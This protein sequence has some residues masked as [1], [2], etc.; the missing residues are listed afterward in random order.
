MA[1]FLLQWW[2]WPART[3]IL[4]IPHAVDIERFAFRPPL[5]SSTGTPWPPGGRPLRLVAIGH[6]ARHKEQHVLVAMVAALRERGVEAHLSLTVDPDDDPAY[7]AELQSAVT[8]RGLTAHVE[9]TGR[10]DDPATLLA[11]ADIAL[12]ASRSESFGFPLIEAMAAGVPVV[13][14]D[15]PASREVAGRFGWF[16]PTGDA[17]AAADAVQAV[18]ATPVDVL[19]ARLEAAHAAVVER[20]GWSRN[21]EAVAAAVEDAVRR[22]GTSPGAGRRGAQAGRVGSG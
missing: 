7:V 6:A 21:A 2:G 11:G 5:R 13:A 19:A 12:S 14:S 20:F 10:V 8:D 4:V 15:I 1:G 16:F 9:L 22:R 18:L 17:A 3:P